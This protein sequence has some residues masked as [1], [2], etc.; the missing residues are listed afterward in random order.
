MQ[1]LV[2][3]LYRENDL[4][5]IHNMICNWRRCCLLR[6]SYFAFRS[7]LTVS[8]TLSH[9][10]HTIYFAAVTDR[11]LSAFIDYLDIL[12]NKVVLVQNV[13]LVL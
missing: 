3:L 2:L 1:D 10:C 7:F 9:S 6:L 11:R 4:I 13:N 12:F 8:G 5:N